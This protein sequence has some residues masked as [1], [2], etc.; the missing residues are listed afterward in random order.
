MILALR[1]EAKGGLL[2]VV[3]EG[4]L[5]AQHGVHDDATGPHVH[6]GRVLLSRDNRGSESVVSP[7]SNQINSTRI[8]AFEPRGVTAVLGQSTRGLVV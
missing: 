4:E 8:F 7:A 3:V 5:P 6:R 2:V 1:D